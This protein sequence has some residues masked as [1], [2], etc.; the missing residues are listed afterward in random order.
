[1]KSVDQ[2]LRDPAGLHARIERGE[3]LGALVRTMVATIAAAAALFGAAIGSYRGGVQIA[4]AAVKL[5]IVLLVTAALC[6]PTLSALRL[7]R[8]LPVA[9]ARELARLLA[10]LAFGALVLVA[11]APIVLL[12][13]A[14]DVGY[15]QTALVFFGCVAVAGC[16]A[17]RM[18]ARGLGREAAMVVWT[19]VA[20]F[21]LVGAQVSW[22]LRPYLVRP[23]T[24]EVPF[25]REIEGSL[26]DAILKSTQSARGRYEEAAR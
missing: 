1:V 19:T 3:D 20:V 8:G 6:V 25:V 10:A 17:V 18:L 21:A 14:V 2:L 15:H 16:A 24:Q 9:P 13:R 12:A 4:Y 7:A 23:K 26:F 22:T 5:P 11:E